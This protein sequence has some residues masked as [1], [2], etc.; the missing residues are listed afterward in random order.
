MRDLSLYSEAIVVA[1]SGTE[2][3]E[4]DLLHMCDLHRVIISGAGTITITATPIEKN[5][6][7]GG[8]VQ[9]IVTSAAA[10]YDTYLFRGAQKL[11]FTETGGAATA[12]VN[13]YSYNH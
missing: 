4:P 2:D 7:P 6:D 5:N 8:A 13:V 9:T 3:Y 10:G 11:T 1:I 12:T